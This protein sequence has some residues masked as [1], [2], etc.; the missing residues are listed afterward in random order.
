[1][2]IAP[3]TDR[4]NEGERDWSFV[5]DPHD[6][7][8]AWQ[9]REDLLLPD[10]YRN[11][12]LRYNG[13]RVYPRLFRSDSALGMRLGPYVCESDEMYCDLIFPWSYVEHH[14]RGETYGKGVPPRHLVFAETPG[15]IQLL[16][17]LTPE[18]Y[19]RVYAWMHSNWDWGEEGNNLI[20]P[21]ANSFLEF[22]SSLYDDDQNSD[23]QQW[24]SPIYDQLAKEFQLEDLQ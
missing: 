15:S 10:S 5:E 11:F 18:N 16:M 19:G 22:L 1:M 14:W 23:Y 13:G 6:E 7:I 12:M 3:Y 21:L 8:D 24:H 9:K 2:K 17:A 20:F 4:W